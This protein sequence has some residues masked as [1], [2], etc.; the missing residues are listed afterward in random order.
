VKALQAGITHLEPL[1][2][3]ARG[4]FIFEWHGG[5]RVEVYTGP[6]KPMID[7]FL[8]ADWVD[9]LSVWSLPTEAQ[10]HEACL[11]YEP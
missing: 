8:V 3:R 1:A 2:R 6:L 9:G 4:G 10:F 11:R 7:E 5:D